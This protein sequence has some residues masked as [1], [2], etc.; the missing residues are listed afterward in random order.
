MRPQQGPDGPI[1]VTN[2]PN[3]GGVVRPG[4]PVKVETTEPGTVYLTPLYVPSAGEESK[5]DVDGSGKE[6]ELPQNLK[7]GTTFVVSFWPRNGGAPTWF[8]FEVVDAL[9]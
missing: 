8:T 1:K 7:P 9:R 6:T 4:E 5:K 2:P 3:G